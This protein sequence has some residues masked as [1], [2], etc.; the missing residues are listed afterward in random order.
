MSRLV[1]FVLLAVASMGSTTNP[2]VKVRITKNGIEYG[3]WIAHLQQF[4]IRVH[5]YR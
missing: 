5:V 4:I 3:K 2:G 1:F